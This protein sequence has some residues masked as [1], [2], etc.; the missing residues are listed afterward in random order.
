MF[1]LLITEKLITI[2]GLFNLNDKRG[3]VR[4]TQEYFLQPSTQPSRNESGLRV[5][6]L[7]KTEKKCFSIFVSA[8][9]NL[10]KIFR[11][12]FPTAQKKSSF[13]NSNEAVHPWASFHTSIVFS[14]RYCDIVFRDLFFIESS[15]VRMR[16]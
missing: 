11:S 13:S 2:S 15:I 12:I 7:P 5:G 8:L 14:S 10:S 9:T 3:N 6:I 1:I 4:H 16:S